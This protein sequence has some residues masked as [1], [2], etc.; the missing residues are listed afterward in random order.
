MQKKHKRWIKREWVR[1]CLG[2]SG[3]KEA[4]IK[5]KPGFTS[6]EYASLLK[7][8]QA[9]KASSPTTLFQHKMIQILIQLCAFCT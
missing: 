1:L 2:S 8:F 5:Y 7:G 6:M 3:T 9:F 4:A